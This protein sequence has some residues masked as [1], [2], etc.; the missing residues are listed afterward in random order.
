MIRRLVPRFSS[1]DC[2]T[3]SIPK[4]TPSLHFNPIVVLNPINK[5][6]LSRRIGTQKFWVPAAFS[7]L[8]RIFYLENSA[9]R[10]I[11]GGRQVILMNGME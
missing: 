7:C 4:T 5:L 3:F 1:L 6:E 2:K 10:R 11:S 8:S 9:V